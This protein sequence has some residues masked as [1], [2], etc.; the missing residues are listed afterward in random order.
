MVRISAPLIPYELQ[1]ISDSR[2]SESFLH[3]A[4]GI[5]ACSSQPI[6]TTKESPM[7]NTR[8]GCFCDGGL[9]PL[10]S[11]PDHIS[12]PEVAGKTGGLSGMYVAWRW[13]SWAQTNPPA[14]AVTIA[15]RRGLKIWLILGRLT[16]NLLNTNFHDFILAGRW[17]VRVC[18]SRRLAA[19]GIFAWICNVKLL[20]RF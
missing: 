13:A 19:H 16:L 10:S 11:R 5:T 8:F 9:E 12:K 1:T 20:N 6:P 18:H 14:V 17:C 2:S 7:I 3:R 15:I 4:W